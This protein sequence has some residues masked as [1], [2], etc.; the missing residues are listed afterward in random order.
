[1][2]SVIIVLMVFMLMGLGT[3]VSAEDS[4]VD[5][6]CVK[7]GLGIPIGKFFIGVGFKQYNAAPGCDQSI[8]IGLGIG[9]ETGRF[10]M[11]FGYNQGVIGFSFAIKGPDQ[12]T[13]IG[14]AIGYDYGDCRLVWPIEE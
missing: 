7:G 1:M 9:K 13:L 8:G 10:Q 6:D 5:C 11:G 12:V 3:P 2:K 14:P 4:E